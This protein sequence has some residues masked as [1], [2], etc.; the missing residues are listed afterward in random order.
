MGSSPGGGGGKY[1]YS[2]N[3]YQ[4]SLMN[5]RYGIVL[6]TELDV[7]CDKLAVDKSTFVELH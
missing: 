2:R 5:P 4:Q 1:T 6:W 3:K 7:H